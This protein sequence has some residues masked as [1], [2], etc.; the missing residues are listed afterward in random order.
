MDG[1]TPSPY[2]HETILY[3]SVALAYFRVFQF[4]GHLFFLNSL[5]IFGLAVLW[6][7]AVNVSEARFL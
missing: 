6:S 2:M 5:D 1:N 3:G 4:F 7:V